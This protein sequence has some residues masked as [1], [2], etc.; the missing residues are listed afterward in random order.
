MT[1]LIRLDGYGLVCCDSRYFATEGTMMDQGDY[2][3][4]HPPRCI[5]GF[6]A[7]LVELPEVEFD[8][9]GEPHNPVF[10]LACRCGS[11]QLKV[12]GYRWV[13]DSGRVFLLSPLA[14]EC[15][16]C[17][18]RTELF[19][20]GTHGY[21]GE[22]SHSGARRAEGEPVVDD[23]GA[24]GE[25]VVEVFARFEY[26]TDLFGGGYPEFAGREQDLFTWFSLVGRCCACGQML[27]FADAEC[28]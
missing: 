9:H 15:A 5:A 17:G 26:P 8:G 22:L 23:C 18:Q 14:A 25:Q 10:A 24:C 16:A 4:T 28:A 12:H 1:A 21:D 13:H 6:T 19:D 27:G 11:R 2:F 7:T 3:R 20:A